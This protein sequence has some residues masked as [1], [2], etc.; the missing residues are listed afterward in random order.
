[1]ATWDVGGVS[2]IPS[3]GPV[4]NHGEVVRSTYTHVTLHTSCGDSS[5]R[6][7]L[8]D[9]FVTSFKLCWISRAESSTVGI[10]QSS[11]HAHKVGRRHIMVPIRAIRVASY[12]MWSGR[13]HVHLKFGGEMILT[14]PERATFLGVLEREMHGSHIYSEFSFWRRLAAEYPDPMDHREVVVAETERLF[15]NE[16]AILENREHKA[17]NSSP[18]LVVVPPGAAK[19]LANVSK[20][21]VGHPPRVVW[22]GKAFRDSFIVRSGFPRTSKHTTAFAN[23][24]MNISSISEPEREHPHLVF[25]HLARRTRWGFSSHVGMD[26]I[27]DNRFLHRPLLSPR[28]LALAYNSIRSNTAATARTAKAWRKNLVDVLSITSECVRLIVEKKCSLWISSWNGSD[29]AIVLSSLLHICLD[30]Q[31]RSI[32]GFE[33]LIEK[34]WLQGGHMFAARLGIL[35]DPDIKPDSK[36]HR[37]EVS[38]MFLLFIEAVRSLLLQVPSAFEF[39]EL[40]LVHLLD[41]A[42]S[43]KT[44]TFQADSP[45]QRLAMKFNETGPSAWAYL[46]GSSLH[47]FH[48]NA[49]YSTCAD[50]DIDDGAYNRDESTR[51]ILP[52]AVVE[53]PF[54]YHV[55]SR[56]YHLTAPDSL[57]PPM[58][59]LDARVSQ[60][61]SSTPTSGTVT[62]TDPVELDRPAGDGL[63]LSYVDMAVVG[64]SGRGS[65]GAGQPPQKSRGVVFSL[66]YTPRPVY[67]KAVDEPQNNNNY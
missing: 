38:P 12:H 21:T 23:E 54:W 60:I 41:V 4:L 61:R 7:E 67:N 37:H 26:S 50:V 44:A 28:D 16:W 51:P 45:A 53:P 27:D 19:N 43:G 25:V 59:R 11:Y 22:Q 13:V 49:Q 3:S 8:G 55:H 2:Y 30:P 31:Y 62:I 6:E 52:D 42:Y 1:M 64:S 36:D 39:N 14:F 20:H 29:R 58:Q 34:E 15:T 56:Y 24:A 9:L 63:T 46:N 65:D 48:L 5:S 17:M 57:G 10:Y 35:V 33:L 32:K 66:P 18:L 40:F 47:P